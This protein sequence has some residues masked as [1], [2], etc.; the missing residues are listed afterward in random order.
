MYRISLVSYS[1][2]LPFKEALYN[3]EFVAKNAILQER[4][5]AMCAED[6]FTGEADISLVPIGAFPIP[7]TQELLRFLFGSKK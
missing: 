1:N 2:T 7:K 6:I 3:S 5:P 4:I